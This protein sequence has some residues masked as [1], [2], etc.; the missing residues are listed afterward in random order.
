MS[1]IKILSIV[2]TLL[3]VACGGEDE[4]I[5]LPT[6][7]AG[8]GDVAVAN[9]NVPAQEAAQLD[10]NFDGLSAGDY[11]LMLTGDLTSTGNY[12]GD[13]ISNP[14]YAIVDGNNSQGTRRVN[15]VANIEPF[16]PFEG[17]NQAMVQFILPD[18]LTPGSYDIVPRDDENEGQVQAEVDS[19]TAM[20]F[21][22]DDEVSGTLTVAEVG[23]VFSGVF[24]LTAVGVRFADDAR[25]TVNASGRAFQIPFRFRPQMTA[26]F[27]MLI[28][29]SIDHQ[30]SLVDDTDETSQVNFT[31]DDF[32]DE[33]NI[34]LF[35]S[36][37]DFTN[38]IELNFWLASDIT[39]GTYNVIADTGL[40]GS[41]YVP[42]EASVTARVSIDDEANDIDYFTNE[43]TGSFTFSED[44]NGRLQGTFDI[45]GAD[46]E[47]GELINVSGMFD[48]LPNRFTDNQ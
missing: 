4:D 6:R 30:A 2:L 40:S 26:E 1:K 27:S 39:P 31:Y 48:H 21:E 38:T 18:G 19:G 12:T 17:E 8:N 9:D 20:G 34:T 25:F 24:E 37:A 23:D 29:A 22:F 3:L 5:V 47:T 13:A 14:I 43:I 32:N 16:E 33:Y 41:A 7:A 10:A 46:T 36:N 44:A 42:E 45:S 28:T 35:R 11:E 15:L